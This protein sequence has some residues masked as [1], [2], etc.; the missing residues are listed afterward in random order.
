MDLIIED[1]VHIVYVYKLIFNLIFKNTNK[2]LWN[3]QAYLPE[4]HW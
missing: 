2:L 1:S 3:I 4:E